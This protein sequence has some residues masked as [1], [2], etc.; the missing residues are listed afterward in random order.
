MLEEIKECLDLKLQSDQPGQRKSPTESNDGKTPPGA[1]QW[2][3]QGRPPNEG[4]GKLLA[5]RKFT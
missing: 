4:T 3:P 5:G 1:P 2:T